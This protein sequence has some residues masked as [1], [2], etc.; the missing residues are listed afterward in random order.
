VAPLSGVHFRKEL[1]HAAAEAATTLGVQA[2]WQLQLLGQPVTVGQ[3]S[4]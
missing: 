1:K 3:F 2:P 4:W